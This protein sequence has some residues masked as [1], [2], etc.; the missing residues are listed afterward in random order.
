MIKQLITVGILIAFIG[1]TVQPKQGPP[2]PQGEPGPPGPPGKQGPI[3]ETG[4]AGPPGPQGPP[5][6]PGKSVPPELITRLDAQLNALSAFEQTLSRES[7][8]GS[9]FYY[10]GIAPPIIGFTVLT[11]YGNVYRMDNINPLTVGNTFKYVGRIDKRKDF[12]SMTV[13]PSGEGNNQFF[14][15]ITRNGNYYISSDLKSWTLTGAIPL[16]DD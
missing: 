15:A 16:T 10:F 6:T 4:P 1:C 14:L 12:I 5:G 13:I 3:G 9:A 2:G 8:V 11:S 7:I